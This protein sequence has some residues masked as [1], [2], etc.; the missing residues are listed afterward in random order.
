MRKWVTPLLV[1]AALLLV[2]CENMNRDDTHHSSSPTTQPRMMSADA[3][4][5]CPG[6]QT[7]T[8]DGKCPKCRMKM[9]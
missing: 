3:C 9:Q 4:P 5:H 8:T 7:A 2:G 1:V 6:V